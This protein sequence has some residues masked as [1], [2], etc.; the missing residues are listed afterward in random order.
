M[1][2]LFAMATSTFTSQ[3][4]ASSPCG[5]TLEPMYPMPHP[6]V[7]GPKPRIAWLCRPPWLPSMPSYQTCQ[8]RS[9]PITSLLP[10]LSSSPESVIPTAMSSLTFKCV[11][12]QCSSLVLVV[13]IVFLLLFVL[14]LS[15]YV[16]KSSMRVLLSLSLLVL[17]LPSYPSLFSC[18]PPYPSLFSCCPPIPPCSPAAL[19]SLLVLL[20]PSYPSLFSCCPPIPP[21][22]PAALLIPPCSP[23]ALLSLLVLL[24]PSYP[25]L[26]SCCP[27]YP[28]LFSCCPP[29]PSLFSCCPPY[30]S[31]FSCCPPYPSLFS[32]CPPYPSLFSCCPPCSLAQSIILNL[33]KHYPQQSLWMMMAVSKV[34]VAYCALVC[35]V[36]ADLH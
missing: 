16:C 29:Y 1:V 21:C 11:C 27:P 35:P 36:S 33:I 5:W 4:P 31:L 34:R 28:S 6:P 26:F 10:S 32:C 13:Y 3:F 8:R 25:S 20:L 30:P 7:V 14:F 9:L 12:S 15:I 22:S 18:C 17:L 24:L 2:T 19:L 23:A